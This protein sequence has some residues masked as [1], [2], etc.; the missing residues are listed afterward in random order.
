VTFGFV[1]RGGSSVELVWARDSALS[2][3]SS[4]SGFVWTPSSLLPFCCPSSKLSRLY[5]PEVGSSFRIVSLNLQGAFLSARGPVTCL[6]LIANYR[7][8]VAVLQ[9]CKKSWL[10][11]IC[12]AA[13]ME[14]LLSYEVPPEM[15]FSFRDGRPIAVRAA[16]RMETSW[17]IPD[18]DFQPKVVRARIPE[19]TIPNYEELPENLACRYSGRALLAQLSLE[20]RGLWP[21]RFTPLR[22]REG[23]M[24]AR[25]T[26]SNRFSTMQS[27]WRS[28]T[29]ASPTCSRSTPMSHSRKHSTE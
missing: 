10:A 21:H 3:D 12:A 16:V 22:A 6:D 27:P 17:R 2:R 20:A 7:P 5:A 1:D 14:G 18:G 28:M 15:P 29:W 8:D 4:S 24:P 19:E 9:E 26:S 25:F 23:S 11:E 13:G